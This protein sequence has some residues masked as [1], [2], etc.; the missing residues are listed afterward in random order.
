[1]ATFSTNEV[2]QIIVG[3]SVDTTGKAKG[4][5]VTAKNFDNKCFFIEYV[6][7]DGQL[8]KSDYINYDK[9][10]FAKASQYKPHMLRKDEITIPNA[11]NIVAGQDYIVRILFRGWGSGSPEDQYFKFLGAYRAKAGDT[12]EDVLGSLVN[13]GVKNFARE[14]QDLL[15]FALEGTG[16]NAKM[17]VTEKPQPWVLGKKAGYPLN[18][19]IQFVPITVDGTATADWATVTNLY[20]G[21]LGLGTGT[22]AAD[23]EYFFLGERG[24]VYRNVGYPYTWDTKYLVDVSA[25]Y[26]VLDLHYYFSDEAENPQASE[27]QLVILCKTAGDGTHTTINPVITAIN[28][29]YTAAGKTP[30]LTTITAQNTTVVVGGVGTAAA[31]SITGLT[32]GKKFKV[33]IKPGEVGETAKNVAANG[34]LID[35]APVALTGSSITGLTNGTRYQVVQLD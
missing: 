11:N 4:S 18:Y 30:P 25:S 26:D 7:A 35:G 6:N 5:V 21:S 22:L 10:R 19:V 20:Q 1:M 33:I 31:S 24:D 27:K 3:N 16:A 15:D 34:T 32:S 2:R 8:V 29:C 17:I 13:S 9:V 12:A 23:M 28:A 14:D